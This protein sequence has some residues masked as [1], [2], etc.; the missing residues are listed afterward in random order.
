MLARRP[1][2]ALVLALL[3]WAPSANGFIHENLDLTTTAVRFLIALAVAWIAVT[4]IALVIDG[5]GKTP[6]PVEEAPAELP[7]RRTTDHAEPED[8]TLTE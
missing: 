3:V 8:G 1:L 6:G 5:Y 4:V 2:Y 7:R